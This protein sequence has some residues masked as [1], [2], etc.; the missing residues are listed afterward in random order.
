MPAVAR[1]VR[2]GR[3]C[4]SSSLITG[5]NSGRDDTNAYPTFTK[6]LRT[7]R[8]GSSH[9]VDVSVIVVSTSGRRSDYLPRRHA[10]AGE[11]CSTKRPDRHVHVHAT[12]L[13][14]QILATSAD[15]PNRRAAKAAIASVQKNLTGASVGSS[16]STTA[17]KKPTARKSP[18]KRTAAARKTAAKK[19]TTRAT[20]AKKTTARKAAVKKTVAKKAAPRKAAVR[21]TVAKK[22]AQRKAAA[23]KTTARKVAK[24]AA[25][26]KAAAKKTTARKVAK[27]AAPRKAAAKKTTARKV[28]KKA[29]P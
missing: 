24:K 14:G 13:T 3:S 22:A 4:R 8:H 10:R 1:C 17:A 29:A 18:A 12:S 19:T 23:K 5:R 21:K 27:K 16:S 2:R 28:A 26:R 25:P 15:H 20:A 7:M 6:C 11:V 9:H